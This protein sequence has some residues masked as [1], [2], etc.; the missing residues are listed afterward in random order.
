MAGRSRSPPTAFADITKENNVRLTRRHHHWSCQ[1]DRCCNRPPPRNY[2]FAVAV[3]DLE[4]ETSDRTTAAIVEGGGSAV[5][6]AAD[7]SNEE[8]VERAI[9]LVQEKLGA[10]TVLV[11]NGESFATT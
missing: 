9:S 4:Q 2:G 7:V 6:I 8:S 1:G 11:N 5:G 10:P 3:L